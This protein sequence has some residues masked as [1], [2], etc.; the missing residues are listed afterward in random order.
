MNWKEKIKRKGLKIN[1][2]AE[3]IGI[4]RVMLSHYINESRPIPDEIKK[5]LELILM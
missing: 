1:W 3:K 5:Q 4:H 2:I